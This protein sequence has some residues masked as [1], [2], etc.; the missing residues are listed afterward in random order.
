MEI[1]AF[2]FA[3][4]WHFIGTVILLG[5]AVRLILG[6]FAIFVSAVAG[7]KIEVKH[8]DCDCDGNCH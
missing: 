2:I 3:S 4:F 8:C 7:R 1:L 6:L 5:I